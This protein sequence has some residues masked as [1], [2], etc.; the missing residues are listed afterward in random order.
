[1]Q[2]DLS[3]FSLHSSKTVA[4]LPMANSTAATPI[5]IHYSCNKA[6]KR[7]VFLSLSSQPWANSLR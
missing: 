2:H 7:I 1:M 6:Q 3:S 4:I 5:D